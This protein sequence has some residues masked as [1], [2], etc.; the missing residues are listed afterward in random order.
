MIKKLKNLVVKLN[1]MNIFCLLFY[2]LRAFKVKNNRII[3]VSYHGKGYGDSGKYVVEELLKEKDK[4]EIIWATKKK[5]KMPTDIKQ[6]K[7]NSFSYFY[8]LSTA[9]IWVNNARFPQY[10]RKR[11]NQFYI[12]LWHGGL[13]LK[14]IEYDAFDKMTP[15]YKKW[16]ENDTNMTDLMVSNSN[17]CTNMYKRAFKYNGEIKEYGTPRNDSLINNINE[18]SSKVRD[19]YSIKENENLVLYAP[20]FRNKYD[21]NPY[22]INFKELQKTLERKKSV[23][24]KIIC[25]LHP[26]IKE[27]NKIID[28]NCEFINATDYPDMQELIA[29]CDILITDYSST[30]FEAMIANKPVIIYANDIQEYNDERGMYFSFNELPFPLCKNNNEIL[31]YIENN[32]IENII[33]NYPEFKQKIGIKEYGKASIEVANRIVKIIG[34]EK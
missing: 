27:H 33:S 4:Y 10:V 18:L 13:A 23:K 21:A 26:I 28:V 34:E 9:K 16:M 17:F 2:I 31:E 3:F 11:K 14:K 22:D 1:I 6:I 7:F 5:E 32:K 29:A 25:R 19:Y 30:M 20:T 15:Y 24:W 12:Q 8:Y